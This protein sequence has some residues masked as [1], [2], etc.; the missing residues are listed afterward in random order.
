[1]WS[2]VMSENKVSKVIFLDIDGVLHPMSKIK[3][4]E[5]SKEKINC[6]GLFKYAQPLAKTINIAKHMVKANSGKDLEVVIF[7]HSAW[8]FHWSADEIREFLKDSI[9]E[10]IV[11]V[12]DVEIQPRE[13]S[14]EA[15]IGMMGDSCDYLVIDDSHEEFEL[16]VIPIKR[17]LFVD[18][19]IC[20]NR[21]YLDK[22]VA[23]LMKK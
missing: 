23:F 15:A 3:G 21:I 14:I 6:A 5:W 22:V 10:Y 1:M 8:R 9:G 7:I 16:K 17:T 11:N 2:N 12:T 20:L 13:K 18:S 4:F 19:E